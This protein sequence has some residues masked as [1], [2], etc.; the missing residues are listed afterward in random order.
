MNYRYED[1]N[2]EISVKRTQ[3]KKASPSRPRE[4][5]SGEKDQ[6][7]RRAKKPQEKP[8]SSGKRTTSSAGR[9][10]K[11]GPPSQGKRRPAPARGYREYDDYA[12][13][14]HTPRKKPRRKKRTNP[15]VALVYWL[16]AI[17]IAFG[18]S[19]FIK[20]Y[21]FEIIRVSGDGM[22]Q[23]LMNG[24]LALVTK[25][26]YKDASP[27]RGDVV[28]VTVDGNKGMML[29]RVV[30]LPGETVE[31]LGGDTMVNGSKLL[32]QYIGLRTYDTFEGKTMPPDKYYLLG[33][34]RTETNDSRDNQ[35][36]LVDKEDIVGQVRWVIWPLNHLGSL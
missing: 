2:Q 7:S 30:G 13:V 32:E 20:E 34:N 4:K 8:V 16:L 19:Y 31:I 3:K 26:D 28:A 14:R 1:D 25:F 22:Y 24:D 10:V 5:V 18:A 33:D 6:P 12:P 15:L 27:Q 23:T 35:I 21:G 29:R 17:A 36:G 9:S 11:K